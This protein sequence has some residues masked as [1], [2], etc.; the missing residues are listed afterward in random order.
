[1]SKVSTWLKASRVTVFDYLDKKDPPF[2]PS[3]S[4]WRV[5]IFL[6]DVSHGA[7][8]IFKKPQKSDALF[9]LQL[10]D[11]KMLQ[12]IHQKMIKQAIVRRLQKMKAAPAH[13]P[14]WHPPTVISPHSLKTLPFSWIAWAAKS[15]MRSSKCNPQQGRDLAPAVQQL[16]WILLPHRVGLLLSKPPKM[17]LCWRYCNWY[18]LITWSPSNSESSWKHYALKDHFC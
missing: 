4:C 18:F 1:M 2:K 15:A 17:R 13:E 7:T 11:I 9:L 3:C 6:K 10:Q 12:T 5:V 16:Y 14:V 8:A